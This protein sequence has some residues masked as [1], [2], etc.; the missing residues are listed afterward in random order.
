MRLLCQHLILIPFSLFARTANANGFTLLPDGSISVQIYAP[1]A[2]AVSVAGSWNFWTPWSDNLVSNR[3]GWW[4]AKFA[5]RRGIAVGT[6]YKFVLLQQNGQLLWKGDPWSRNQDGKEL[7]NSLAYDDTAFVWSDSHWTMPDWKQLVIYELHVGTFG[8]SATKSVPATLDDCIKK[9]DHLVQ[10]GINAVE[11]LPV[12][13][14][15]GTTD[16]GYTSSYLYAVESAYGGT[17]AFKRF[18]NAAHLKGIAVLMDVVY[19]HLG[20]MDLALWQFD[21]WFNA[22]ATGPSGGIYFYNDQRAETPWAHTRPNYALQHVRSYLLDNARYWLDTMHCD[23]LRVDGVSFIRL[24]GGNI[25]RFNAVFNPDGEAILKQ[26]T[27]LSHSIAGRKLIVAEDLQS[28]ATLTKRI[29]DRGL[30]FDSQWDIRFMWNVTQAMLKQSD[31]SWSLNQI[32]VAI[33]SQRLGS[34]LRRTIYAENHDTASTDGYLPTIFLQGQTSANA[35]D[36]ARKQS[37][38]IAALVLTSPGIPLLFQ[39]QELLVD[40]KFSASRP[41]NW[42]KKASDFGI[43]ALHRDLISL[44]R[45]LKQTS[46]GLQGNGVN[47]SIDYAN[48]VLTVYRWSAGGPGDDTFIVFNFFSKDLKSLRL[49]FPSAG[50]WKLSFNS[51]SPQYRPGITIQEDPDTQDITLNTDALQIAEVSLPKFSCLIYTRPVR[52]RLLT[53]VVSEQSQS[54]DKPTEVFL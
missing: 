43:F 15:S 16:M 33:T 19:N 6:P 21:G 51:T 54:Q 48:Q 1:N 37:A 39:G 14:F 13:E 18:V 29:D 50:V 30:G 12:A 3:S 38:L 25:D 17:D 32:K 53:E 2:K 4:S 46:A 7:G 8:S 41:L 22:S 31:P 36:R 52:T 27:G 10:L 49:S 34:S 47:T 45:N 24:W 11:I 20:P 5:K 26:L 42:D 28:N 9:L 23:G 44:R 40:G 35:I